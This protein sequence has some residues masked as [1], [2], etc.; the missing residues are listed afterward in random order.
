MATAKAEQKR[1]RNR[2]ALVRS[3][4]ADPSLHREGVDALWRL[5]R[6]ANQYTERS[7]RDADLLLAWWNA[8]S[9]GG[10]DLADLWSVD[11]EIADDMMRVLSLIRQTKAYPGTLSPTIHA[12]FKSLVTSRRPHLVDE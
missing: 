12:A 10:F 6:I 1:R 4:P 8:T 11:R 7:K 3:E 5:I 9:C 2:D